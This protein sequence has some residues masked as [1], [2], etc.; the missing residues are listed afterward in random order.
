MLDLLVE[1][2]AA[3]VPS[4]PSAPA[5][6]LALV[7]RGA[8]EMARAP[9]LHG[10]RSHDRIAGF[11]DEDLFIRNNGL[12]ALLDDWYDAGDPEARRFGSFLPP[13]EFGRF[14]VAAD[15]A[16][17]RLAAETRAGGHH[18]VDEAAVRA[19]RALL[20]AG[21][22][23]VIVSNSGTSRILDLL[24][25]KKGLG[26]VAHDEDPSAP[27]RI[28]GGAQKFTLSDSP[29]GYDVGPYRI[30]TDRPTYLKILR[31]EKPAAVI[32]D[33]FSLDLGLPAALA[34]ESAD[35]RD[36]RL[37]LRVRPYTPA[38]SRAY[39]ANGVGAWARQIDSLDSDFAANWASDR[40]R[41]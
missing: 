27:L 23:V 11:A 33:V 38:W 15:R 39:L 3:V 21:H 29:A 13:S 16:F 35:F 40:S 26:A 28:R 12:A 36:L 25:N 10:W 1:E 41:S 24:L 2:I 4:D 18:P 17:D 9:H 14:G 37:F 30:H 31:E 5:A 32:G 6:A 7:S 34:R 20:E 19:L 8:S 22:R